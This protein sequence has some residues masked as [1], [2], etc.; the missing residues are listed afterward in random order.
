M[1]NNKYWLHRISHEWDAAYKLLSEG[2]LTIGWSSLY[3]SGIDK[4]KDVKEFEKIMTEHNYSIYRSR[5]NLW[6]F[7][8]FRYNDYIIVPLFN[9]KFSVYRIKGQ[10]LPISE[11]NGFKDFKADNNDTISRNS[12]G[13]LYH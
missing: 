9:G 7:L 13:L 4:V 5:R 11:L 6:N 10:A 8:N 2:W 3:D 1:E 12:N